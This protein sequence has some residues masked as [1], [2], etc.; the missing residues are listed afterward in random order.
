MTD[1]P[2]FERPGG[3]Q[4]SAWLARTVVQGLVLGIAF[5]TSY[6]SFNWIAQLNQPKNTFA[7]EILVRQQAE[8][9]QS[10]KKAA[11]MIARSEAILSNQ[12]A[13]IKRLDAVIAAW[14]RQT[15]ITK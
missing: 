9:D 6:W 10:A 14:E 15:G 11:Q 1:L 2:Q 5:A 12:E 7:Q 4:Q 13:Q 8:Y 3:T